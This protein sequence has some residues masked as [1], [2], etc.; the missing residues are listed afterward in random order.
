MLREIRIRNFAIIES[1]DLELTPGFNVFT[2]ETGAGK[3]IILDALSIVLGEK[4]DTSFVR[5]GTQR[6]SIE[7][8]FDYGNRHEEITEV[9]ERGRGLHPPHV[10][11]TYSDSCA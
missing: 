11:V 4:S 2:G 9:L 3:S 7:A 1:L 10:W 8:V 6:A 5:E